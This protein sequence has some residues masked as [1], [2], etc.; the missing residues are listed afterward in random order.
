M[1]EVVAPKS[2]A[3]VPVLPGNLV[4]VPVPLSPRL[5]KYRRM[6]LYVAPVAAMILSWGGA[7]GLHYMITNPA[8]VAAIVDREPPSGSRLYAQHCAQCHGE[9]GDGRGVSL[10][11]PPARHFGAEP[12]KF[13]TTSNRMSPTDADLARV[14]QH[15]IP[16]SAMPAFAQLSEDERQA[17]VGHVR[18]LTWENLYAKLRDKAVKDEGDYDSLDVAERADAMTRPGQPLEIPVQFSAPTPELLAQGQ[19]VYMQGCAPCHGPEGKGDG[20]QVKDLKNENGTPA[21]PRDLTQGVYKGGSDP[22]QLYARIVLGIPGTPM[23]AT[24]NLPPQDVDALI[25]Y[26]RSLSGPA[27]HG[28]FVIGH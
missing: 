8:P 10:L 28:S 9:R 4:A 15:G 13:G 20:P 7:V 5:S 21:R 3:D 2:E 17:L 6:I 24:N 22:H 23:P 1:A 25:A 14:I 19:K 26:V 12:F 16:G 27:R 18:R 11:D